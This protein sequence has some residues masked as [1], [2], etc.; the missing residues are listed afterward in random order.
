V[1]SLAAG[2]RALYAFL[3][4]S[5]SEV[6][7]RKAWQIAAVYGVAALGVIQAA[8]LVFP[9]LL[10]PEWTITFVVAVVLLGLPLALALA[11]GYEIR[12]GV[13]EP[14][15]GAG[16]PRGRG[17]RGA[18]PD[19][20]GDG[21]P[22]RSSSTPPALSADPPSLFADRSIVV[23][24]FENLSP[25]L[26]N[27]YFC[28]GLTDEIITNLS[29]LRSLRVISRTS[30]M[31]LKG[32]GMDERTIG[33]ELSVRYI[34]GG[35]VRK[36]GARLRVTAQLVD[37]VT[38][39]HLWAERYDGELGDV[40]SIQ[41]DVARSIADALRIELTPEQARILAVHAVPDTYAY[42]CVLRARHG[43]WTGTEVSIRAA[44]R[45]LD[46]AHDVVGE[47][48]AILSAMGEAWFMLPHV[49]G[50]G[51]T[52]L[53]AR[54]EQLAVRILM[55]D[56]SSSAGHFNR[57]LS[58]VKRPWRFMEGLQEFR[59]AGELD[60]TD[61]TILSFHAYVAA[62]AGHIEEG[63]EASERLLHLDPLSPVA[64]LN[65]AYV[66]TLA[67]RVAE[68][69]SEARR[70]V[71]MDPTSNYLRL[72]MLVALA[73]ADS[74]EQSRLLG[75]EVASPPADNWSRMILLYDAALDGRSLDPFLAP[76]LLGAA[77]GDETFSW[78]L[79]QCLTRAGRVNAGLTWL[80]NAVSYGFTNTRFLGERDVMF[81]AVRGEPR[82]QA[83]LARAGAAALA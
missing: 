73:Q 60:P 47:N 3:R 18:A 32:S 22:L 68:A 40:F 29:R 80:E 63:L 14:I 49:T 59:R 17:V 78:M 54:L 7:R 79:A 43:I 21:P 9:R 56:P 53:A 82:F 24:P 41:D 77:R 39:A 23:L 2:L 34:L 62:Q 38:C 83:L 48:V 13:V 11:W 45:Y 44:I 26:N 28:D 27:E 20:F 50:S 74:S 35:S 75:A 81:A 58:L 72:F 55:L 76:E 57:G 71:A 31:L 12:N 67:G 42:D 65:R 52:D 37:S 46:A 64:R 5:L 10:L 70:G 33:R 19:A 36:A 69:V 51:M 25:D 8:D 66:L 30:A 1:T 61:A 15:A 16:R 4:S 6:R